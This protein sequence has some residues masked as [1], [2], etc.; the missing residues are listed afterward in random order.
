MAYS[1]VVTLT[2]SR[3]SGLLDVSPNPFHGQVTARISLSHA[4]G[5]SI[6]LIDSRGTVLRQA[7][8]QGVSGANTFTID[9]SALPPSVY[10][11]QIVLA[12]RVFVRKL[13][14]TR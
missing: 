4:E 6:R 8:Y 10:F 5:V 14:S 7:Q 2:N 13:F 1:D 3:I 9:G 11:V 12:D